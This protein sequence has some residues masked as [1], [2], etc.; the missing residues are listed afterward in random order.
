MNDGWPTR[1]ASRLGDM[2][3][4][5]DLAPI[6]SVEAPIT[7][8]EV[9]AEQDSDHHHPC[10]VLINNSAMKQIKWKKTFRYCTG[11]RLDGCDDDLLQTLR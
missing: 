10:V 4:G 5:I 8:F 7:R 1:V 2:D 6:S 3:M 9:L 11:D